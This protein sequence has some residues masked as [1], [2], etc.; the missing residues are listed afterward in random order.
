MAD[1]GGQD[2]WWPQYAGAT[3]RTQNTPGDK[4][5]MRQRAR[6][7]GENIEHADKDDTQMNAA[8]QYGDGYICFPIHINE[9][10]CVEMMSRTLHCAWLDNIEGVVEWNYDPDNGFFVHISCHDVREELDIL[11]K[12]EQAQSNAY[13]E[14][15]DVNWK[16]KQLCDEQWHFNE[17]RSLPSRKMLHSD[18]R[19]SSPMASKARSEK[20]NEERW[21]SGSEW[22]SNQASSSSWA[23]KEHTSEQGGLEDVKDLTKLSSKE[24]NKAWR[25]YRPEATYAASPAQIRKKVYENETRVRMATAQ[26]SDAWIALNEDGRT[27]NGLEAVKE[28][29]MIVTQLKILKTG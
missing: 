9:R 8:A 2:P 26:E 23:K 27:N 20:W 14:L 6:E 10:A 15:S 4:E 16:F 25:W 1:T 11:E 29:E 19:N 3:K 24:Q 22:W 12:V 17:P 28:R 21:Q 5:R 18:Y 7:A 13:K